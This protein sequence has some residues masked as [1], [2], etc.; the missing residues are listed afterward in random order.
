MHR[1]VASLLSTSSPGR[2]AKLGNALGKRNI[3][4]D[5]TG[6]AEW[7][8]SGPV[9]LII[10][11]DWGKN[12]GDELSGFAD[13]MAEEEFP[14]LAF[15]TIE[16]QLDDRP[17]ELGRAASALGD[18]DINIYAVT[19]LKSDGRKAHLGL[20]VRP[21]KVGEAVDALQRANFVVKPRHHPK[22]PPF[23]PN[24]PDSWW[25]EWDTRT[26][27]LLDWHEANPDTP[28]NHPNFYRRQT[29]D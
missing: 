29:A 14:W 17:G 28:P 4:I 1:Q 13:V 19:V 20:G 15:R 9:T 24:D 6:G 23:D 26:E 2:L 21:S 3:N 18:A 11:D 7:L 27:T 25:D 8:H 12:P 5:T 22:D 10:K 16:I